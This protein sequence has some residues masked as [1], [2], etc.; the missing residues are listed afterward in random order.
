V[1]PPHLLPAPPPVV[2]I[3]ARRLQG[4]RRRGTTVSQAREEGGQRRWPLAVVSRR[5]CG[6]KWRRRR[7]RSSLSAAGRLAVDAEL[8]RP[9]LLASGTALLA[10]RRSSAVVGAGSGVRRGSLARGPSPRGS[11]TSERREE[12]RR[13]TTACC[14]GGPR[15]GRWRHTVGAGLVDADSAQQRRPEVGTTTTSELDLP[16][17][18]ACGFR[19]G[20]PD[21]NGKGP[22]TWPGDNEREKRKKGKK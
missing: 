22:G 3:R 16:G 2:S 18:H 21:A 13:T 15:S 17:G 6:D 12:E 19:C 14:M 8:K 4:A 5:C 10:M 11:P 9:H 1:A 7:S 20:R